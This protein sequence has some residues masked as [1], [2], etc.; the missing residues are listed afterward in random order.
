MNKMMKTMKTMKNTRVTRLW[1]ALLFTGLMSISFYPSRS[2]AVTV[3]IGDKYGGGIVFYILQPGDP[4]YEPGEQHGLIAAVED[5]GRGVEWHTIT[6]QEIG[7]LK[8]E[9]GT[10][11]TNTAAILAQGGHVASAAKLCADYEYDGVSDWYLPSRDELQKMFQNKAVVC[12]FCDAHWSSSEAG[13][14]DVWVNSDTG[15]K[16]HYHMKSIGINVRAIRYY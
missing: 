11:R 1:I 5:Q 3:S 16:G 7:G 10:G 9:I 15:S 14:A 6:S 12:N 13:P 8:T 2:G 4:G